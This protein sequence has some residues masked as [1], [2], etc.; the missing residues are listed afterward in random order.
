MEYDDSSK[1][2]LL[3]KWLQ[4]Y[5][6]NHKRLTESRRAISAK[7][8]GNIAISGIFIAVVFNWIKDIIELKA[9]LQLYETTGFVSAMILFLCS[10][11]LSVFVLF[12]DKFP[13]PKEYTI[14][15]TVLKKHDNICI[16]T[17]N[18]LLFSL[19]EHFEC[20]NEELYKFNKKKG[21]CLFIAQAALSLGIVVIGFVTVVAIMT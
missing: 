1:T 14:I 16:E 7:A 19:N 17:F 12:V 9:I 15:S 21:T 5:Q 2:K 4:S 20:V 11:I 10:I 13:E 3:E 18:D 8:Q 6:E